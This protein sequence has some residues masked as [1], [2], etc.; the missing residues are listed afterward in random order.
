MFTITVCSRRTSRSSTTSS[1]RSSRSDRS[2]VWFTQMDR[3]RNKLKLH[4]L[5]NH[6]QPVI[7]RP[8]NKF[9]PRSGGSFEQR[10]VHAHEAGQVGQPLRDPEL[11]L[12]RGI[13][14]AVHPAL[15]RLIDSAWEAR[16]AAEAHRDLIGEVP[17]VAATEEVADGLI[18]ATRALRDPRYSKRPRLIGLRVLPNNAV[19]APGFVVARSCCGPVLHPRS[20]FSVTACTLFRGRK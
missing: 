12:D 19:E 4:E 2:V 3:A 9:A 1:S 5:E 17:A 15:D 6:L 14:P 13:D 10:L 18:A 8:P 11:A 7:E 20:P 16:P